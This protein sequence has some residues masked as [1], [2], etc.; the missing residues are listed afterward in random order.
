[1]NQTFQLS[2]CED[3]IQDSLPIRLDERIRLYHFSELKSNV[4]SLFRAKSI[5]I[6]LLH[7][8]TDT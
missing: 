4:L 5:G 3:L 6:A 8:I 1:M 2:D 7:A